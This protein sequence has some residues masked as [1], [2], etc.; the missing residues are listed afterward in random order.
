MNFIRARVRRGRA[1]ERVLVE[2]A[3]VRK[4]PAPTS[5]VAVF[6][7]FPKRRSASRS[8]LEKNEQAP[9]SPRPSNADAS[10]RST[11]FSAVTF[12]VKWAIKCAVRTAIIKK[13]GPPSLCGRHRAQAGKQTW[14]RP[15]AIT[16]RFCR[17][18]DHWSALPR[19]RHSAPHEIGFRGS[20]NI[21]DS[22]HVHEERRDRSVPAIHLVDRVIEEAVAESFRIVLHLGLVEAPAQLRLR[23]E[24]IEVEIAFQLRQTLE[25]DRQILRIRLRRTNLPTCRS[26]SSA[27]A[28][29]QTADAARGR[30][31]RSGRRTHSPVSIRSR[32]PPGW[33]TC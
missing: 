25:R 31:R 3:T 11:S 19:A 6:S 8:Q 22:V 7:S 2:I 12:F 20:N 33:K 10:R 17:I 16:A 26:R 1:L 23:V 4:T 21:I 9:S 18:K 28:A 5:S 24:R 30:H 15:T 27:R 13:A 14:R 29:R 32:S